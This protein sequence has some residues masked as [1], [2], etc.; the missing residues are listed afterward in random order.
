MRVFLMRCQRRE[1][2]GRREIGRADPVFN[3]LVDAIFFVGLEIQK[4]GLHKK[5]ALIHV[6]TTS[7]MRMTLNTLP[8][9]CRMFTQV[10]R[11]R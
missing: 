3:K 11:G 2:R 1:E 6:C 10:L 4:Q 8:C 5:M 9:A 7:I